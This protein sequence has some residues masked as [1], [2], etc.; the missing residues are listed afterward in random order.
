MCALYISAVNT[1]SKGCWFGLD[2]L[3][4]NE[5]KSEH[6]IRPERLLFSIFYSV[7]NF[8]TKTKLSIGTQKTK[9]GPLQFLNVESEH[10]AV[11]LVG[12]GGG[13]LG[14]GAVDHPV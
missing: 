9:K 14:D 13:A 4:G 8:N 2:N 3:K 10:G 7:P 6:A 12:P 11:E 1:I 5:S